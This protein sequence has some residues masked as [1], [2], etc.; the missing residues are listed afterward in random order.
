MERHQILVPRS[1][2]FAIESSSSS[3]SISPSVIRLDS[4]CWG[5]DEM[6]RAF[7]CNH[8][9]YEKL[10]IFLRFLSPYKRM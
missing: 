4:I 9:W 5:G 8:I 1:T 7:L 2:S 6:S 10:I 3:A